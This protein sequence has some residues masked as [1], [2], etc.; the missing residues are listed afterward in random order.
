MENLFQAVVVVEDW[1]REK[2]L[3]TVAVESQPEEVVTGPV[4][5]AE[6]AVSVVVTITAV[7]MLK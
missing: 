5:A 3:A 6:I 1:H 4:N 2:V 7:L